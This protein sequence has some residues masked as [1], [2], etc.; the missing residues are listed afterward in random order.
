MPRSRS[1]GKMRAREDM[2]TVAIDVLLVEDSEPDVALALRR[3]SQGGFQCQYRVVDTEAALRLALSERLPSFILSDFSLPGFDGMAALSIANEVA[4]EVPFI[5][6]SGTLGEERAIEA[7]RRGAVDYVLKSNPMRLVPAVKRALSEAELRRATKA[8]ER[9]VARLTGVL[10]MLSEI[11]TAVV[12]IQERKALLEEACRLAHQLGGYP[13]AVIATWDATSRT[14]RPVAASGLLAD[15]A[16]LHIFEVADSENPDTTL[17][18]RVM[19]TG[20]AALC[21]DVAGSEQPVAGRELL[22]AAGIRSLA[23]LPL[24]VDQTPVG[25]FLF[26]AVETDLVSAEEL[27]LLE[28]VAANLSFA[29]QY[30]DKKDAAHFL[31]YF[32]PLTGLAKR[33]LFCERL[34]R[35]L[36]RRA[37]RVPQLAIK[38]FDID[39]LSVINDSYGRHV[40]DLLLQCVADRLKTHCTDTDR[41]AHLGGGTFVNFVALGENPQEEVHG[42]HQ[43]IDRLFE[44]PF[45]FDDREIVITVKCGIACYPA[46]GS[47]PNELVQNAEAALKEAKTSGEKY[48]HHRLE[49]NSA[50]AERVRLESRLRT[51][52]QLQQFEL[53]YQPKIQLRSG[54]IEG[55]EALLRWRDP[56]QGLVAPGRFLPTLESA[57]LMPAVSSWV[58]RQ[59][60]ADCREWRKA[61]LA[62]LRVAVNIAPSELRRRGFVEDVLEGVGDLVNDTHWGIDIE[63]TEGALFGDSSACVH[64]LRWLRTCGLRVAIDDFGTGY[65]SLNR[66]S[67]LPIDSLKIDRIFISRLPADRRSCTLVAAIIDLAHAFDM[68][69]V[70]EGVETQGQLEHLARCGCDESQGYLHSHPL[71]KL[72]F[73]ELLVKAAAGRMD[74]GDTAAADAVI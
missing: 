65:S 11:N 47:E 50:L 73:Q 56:Q 62:P 4:P 16:S 14:A 15:S 22:L 70:A 58:L 48:L 43:E 2:E 33:K 21:N 44:A 55:A 39:H 7:L 38:V 31:T 6:L 74:G 25:A 17:M 66:L 23:C 37:A 57:G 72:Q 52:L 46:N 29:L 34:G 30:L 41:L 64:A 36:G 20:A 60:A 35:L 53:H 32:D 45:I 27:N 13:M 5:F 19:R 1:N 3:L 9:R 67:E 8:A 68:T 10:Q 69:T 28:E 24:I 18:G 71:P 63:V 49:M 26:G 42:L 59:A 40:G 51:A 12:R 61:G 54:R